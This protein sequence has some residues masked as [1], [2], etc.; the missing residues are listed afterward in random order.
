MSDLDFT[1]HECISHG[2][3]RRLVFNSGKY[4]MLTNHK[5]LKELVYITPKWVSVYSLYMIDVLAPSTLRIYILL[6]AFAATGKYT[7]YTP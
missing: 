3:A 5:K 2:L 6:H 7:N 4:V 1:S